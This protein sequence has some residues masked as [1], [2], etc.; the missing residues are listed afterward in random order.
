MATCFQ[1]CPAFSEVE[2]LDYA[3]DQIRAECGLSDRKLDSE[4][5]QL[6]KLHLPGCVACRETITKLLS[7]CRLIDLMFAGREE[8]RQFIGYN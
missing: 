3:L 4:T 5:L 2:I 6:L 1:Q 8:R 7:F